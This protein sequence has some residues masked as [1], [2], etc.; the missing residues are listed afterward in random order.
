MEPV[1]TLLIGKGS[2]KLPDTSTFEPLLP[3]ATNVRL[4]V[5]AQ[6]SLSTHTT[7]ELPCERERVGD[8]PRGLQLMDVVHRFTLRRCIASPL[9]ESLLELAERKEQ[10][11]AECE[12]RLVHIPPGPGSNAGVVKTNKG[13]YQSYPDL[14]EANSPN[15]CG[16]LRDLV[17]V[18][19]TEVVALELDARGH[20]TSYEGDEWLAP[21]PGELHEAYAWLNVNRGANWNAVHQH[22]V[23]RWSAV[24]FVSDG[25]P[26]APGFPCPESGHMLFRCGPKGRPA[27]PATDLAQPSPFSHSYMSV[28]PTPGSLWI[29]PGSVPH[30]VMQAVLPD[31]VAEA[32][33]ARISIGVNFLDAKPPPPHGI[34]PVDPIA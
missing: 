1:S 14:F 2:M 22:D 34:P 28:A 5:A 7:Y 10:A 16:E 32:E 24:Y 15:L 29:F 33:Q 3:Q 12:M 13:G 6:N 8:P 21:A 26:N 18:A 30:A 27:H 19:L 31:G 20:S 11:A 4:S 9:N 23:E 25:E 17:S